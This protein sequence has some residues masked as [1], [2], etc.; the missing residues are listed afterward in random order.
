MTTTGDPADTSTTFSARLREATWG[1]HEKA[2]QA[3]FM[4]ELLAGQVDKAGYASLVAQH[5]FGY[6]A[7]EAAADTMRDDPVASAFVTD[8]LTRMPALEADLADLLGEGW[9]DQITASDATQRYVARI[10]EV[11]STWAG[12]FIAHHYVR[13]MGDLSG[14][15]FIGRVIDRTFGFADHAGTRFY[16]FDQIEDIKAF[17]ERYRQLLDDAPWDEA[18]QRR[19]IDEI[20]LAYQLNTAVLNELP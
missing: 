12:G 7:L 4:Q 1:D 3:P 5:H 15:Q 8:A 2:E 18:E 19:V 11:C 6:Q 20:L 9:A 16:V 10:N 13:Y 14:G 17:K